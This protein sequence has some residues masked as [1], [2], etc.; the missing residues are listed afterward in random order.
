VSHNPARPFKALLIIC[1]CLALTACGGGD[2][3]A[4]SDGGGGGGGGG[5]DGG[6]APS[7]PVGGTITGLTGTV[8][9]ANSSQANGS[10]QLSATTNSVFRFNTAVRSGDTFAVTVKTQPSL[11]P[12]DCTV[13]NGAGVMGDSAITNVAITCTNLP[14]AAAVQAAADVG[15]V[16]LTWSSPDRARSFNVYVSSE[17]SCDIANASSCDDS[18]VQTGA[19]SPLRISGLRNGKPYF[20]QL[21]TVYDNDARGLGAEVGA[22]PNELAFNDGVYALAPTP[23]GSITYVGGAFTQVGITTGAA[24]P[25]DVTDGTLASPGFAI[26]EGSVLAIV[27]DGAGG[28]FLGGT[29][30]SVGGVHVD[31]LAHVLADGSVDTHWHGGTDAAVNALAMSGNV[32]YVGG[33]FTK[34]GTGLTSVRN[35]LA[36]FDATSG[37]LKAWDPN[38]EYVVWALAVTGNAVIAGGAFNQVGGVMQPR[39]AAIDAASGA[40]LPQ[41]APRFTEQSDIVLTLGLSSDAR[42]VFVGGRFQH[43]SGLFRANLAA[44]LAPG[45]GGTGVPTTWSP[46]PD[47]PVK[48]MAVSGDTIYVGGD[49]TRFISLVNPNEI[50]WF[51]AAL[52]ATTGQALPN[53]APGTDFP[54]TTPVGAIAVSDDGGTVYVGGTF[55]FVGG[56]RRSQ[57]AAIGADGKLKSWNPGANRAVRALAVS[58][59]TVYAGGD[60]S[61]VGNLVSRRRLAAIDANGRLT[62]WDPSADDTVLSLTVSPRG[63]VYA[64]GNFESVGNGLTRFCVAELTAEGAATPWNPEILFTVEAIALSG[65]T[66]YAGGFILVVNGELHSGVVALDATT[67]LM[68]NGWADPQIDGDVTSLVVDRGT[69][70][71]G[72]FFS[73]VQG[74]PRI[75]LAAL[76]AVSGQLKADWDAGL[77]GD[78][79]AFALVDHT[80]YAGG[81]FT[82]VNGGSGVVQRNLLAAF[83]TLDEGAT[84]PAVA[85]SWNPDVTGGIDGGFPYVAALA[86]RGQTFYAGGSYTTVNSGT[87]ALSRQS[88]AAFD[89]QGRATAWNPEVP[90]TVAALAVPGDNA[91][92]GGYQFFPTIGKLSVVDPASGERRP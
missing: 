77:N 74:V 83:P 24:V 57:I 70:Y 39:L 92:V 35:R 40:L 91:Y 23:D 1:A 26:V 85:T 38:A 79:W 73:E 82:E 81:D 90:F 71:A 48:A 16:T 51:L 50:R 54:P 30:T 45:A 29:F 31:N 14:T 47:R 58:G 12:Q 53:W 76:N 34:A 18:K 67:G 55:S 43:A 20:F 46:G 21:E 87:A 80:L 4:G 22:R 59:N 56:E 61:S 7:F 6:G 2:T 33:A 10:E 3:R 69:V 15:S 28:W 17:R 63:T 9:L 68:A 5:G 66:V 88:T 11:P 62:S 75:G 72:G 19:T 44:F 52:N 42:T 89:L 36:A 37:E 78:V 25:L 65:N 32:L 13:A 86:I 49:F 41:W 60:F 27:R 8:I 64:G 84:G